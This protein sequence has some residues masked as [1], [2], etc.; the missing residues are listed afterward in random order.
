MRILDININEQQKALYQKEGGGNTWQGL[1]EKGKEQVLTEAQILELS[2]LIVKIEN[3]YGFPCDVEWAYDA[4]KFYIVQSRPITTLG[5]KKIDE[6]KKS[7]IDEFL[8]RGSHEKIL[9]PIT[10]SCIFTQSCTTWYKS[11]LNEV[12]KN[13]ASLDTIMLHR[14]G[15]TWLYFD[16]LKIEALAEEVFEDYIMGGFQ[17]EKL[18]SEIK[19]ASQKITLLYEKLSYKNIKSVSETELLRTAMDVAKN[20]VIVDT[21][22]CFSLL[23]DKPVLS[24]VFEKVG[25]RESVSDDFFMKCQDIP[26]QSFNT[27]QE[28]EYLK[29]KI[30]NLPEEEVMEKMQYA[31]SS[32]AL[33]KNTEQIK[34]IFYEKFNHYNQKEAEIEINRKQDEYLQKRR[35]YDAWYETL[36]GD[37]LKK[38]AKFV[39]MVIE[40]RDMRKNPMLKGYTALFRILEELFERNSLDKKHILNVTFDELFGGSEYLVRNF[41]VIKSRDSG[42]ALFVGYEKGE[43]RF[44]YGVNV[45]EDAQRKIKSIY[46]KEEN[47]SEIFGV[48]GSSG[49]VVG[50][51]RIV[52]FVEQ[53][54]KEFQD[55]EILVAGMTRPEYVPL[56][57]K[58]VAII[59]DEGGIT[60]HAAII[61]R[62]LKIPCIIGTKIA[63]QVLHDGDLVEVDADN[64]VVKIIK[65]AV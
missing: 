18:L 41:E 31:F 44:E 20:F 23:F 9:P 3:H 17:S 64:G 61:S 29:Q 1:G 36:F 13:R 6:E 38:V 34:D 50:R 51:V 30:K 2:E 27:Q 4:G 63:T 55:K 40:I 56:M 14:F 58:A 52:Q 54:T 25:I 11:Y 43:V 62:E 33:I 59:T 49:K 12:Y 22:G 10:S 37:I 19:E 46:L 47:T 28:L 45:F 35:E 16:S 26:H 21:R 48:C 24:I 32:Y 5:T 8:E 65:R 57:K 42:C 60:C 15:K 53:Q 7:I 39:G